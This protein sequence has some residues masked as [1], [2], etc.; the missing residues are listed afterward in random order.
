MEFTAQLQAVRLAHNSLLCV[1]LDPDPSKL[2]QHIAANAA[3]V[4]DFCRA[5]VQ[6]TAQHVLAFKPQIA[7][8]AALGAEDSL[9]KL[10]DFIRSQYPQIPV[11]L[12]AKRGDIGS[13]AKHYAHEAFVRYN[14]H[15]VTLSPYMGFE[16]IAPFLQFADRGLF[17]LCRTSNPGAAAV[18]QLMLHNGLALFEHLAQLISQTWQQ[19]ASRLGYTQALGLVAGATAPQALA[20]VRRLAPAAPL[21]IPGLGAQG[22]DVQATIAAAVG[23]VTHPAGHPAHSAAA[24]PATG[25]VI[26]NS[27]RAIVYAS[28]GRDF[29]QAAQAAAQAMQTALN[30][31]LHQA[32][33]AAPG[34]PTCAPSTLGSG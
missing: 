14:A 25:A 2:P 28:A 18:Q 20:A 17:L 19:D 21:L 9:A 26:V 23:R 34:P 6:A 32:L 30:L 29:A 10:I 22:G 16:S 33:T 31:A 27:S 12:D 3:G 11:I 24:S 7:G 5:I 1:G 4:F 8:F 13:T 15:A